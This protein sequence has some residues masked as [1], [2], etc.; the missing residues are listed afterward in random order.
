MSIGDEWIMIKS[1]N[2]I[3]NIG[4]FSNYRASSPIQLGKF[5]VI[6][7]DNGRGKTTLSAILRSLRANTSG[8]ILG[9]KSLGKQGDSSVVFELMTGLAEFK[10]GQ[11]TLCLPELEIFDTVFIER[12]V[13]S[14]HFVGAAHKRSLL[15]FMLEEKGVELWKALNKNEELLNNKSQEVQSK[16]LEISRLISSGI[17]FDQFIAFQKDDGIEK[18]I[19]AKEQEMAAATQATG[20]K[21]TPYLLPLNIYSLPTPL[22]EAILTR[23]LGGF[24]VEAQKAIH[25]HIKH[26]MDSSGEQWLGA[27]MPF[28]KDNLCPFCG[29]EVKDAMTFPRSLDQLVFKFLS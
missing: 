16:K 3:V 22:Y 4:R 8:H 1:I 26:C 12:N 13:C 2:S 24:V 10:D 20:L 28:L 27:G 14:G 18:K 21:N 17:T 7:A 5:N 15:N 6:C 29:Q 19:E 25:T 11:W 23:T 9:R